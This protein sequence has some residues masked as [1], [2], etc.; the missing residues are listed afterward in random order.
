MDRDALERARRRLAEAD[1]A[2]PSAA[3]IDAVLERARAGLEGLAATAA[4]LEAAVP[5][6]LG[7]AVRASM[8]AEVLPVA[9]QIAEIRGLTGCVVGAVERVGGE[10]AAERAAR[11]EDLALLV[12][13]VA[14]GWRGVERR[15]DRMERLLDR[16]ERSLE[17]RAAAPV[18]RIEAR[19]RRTGS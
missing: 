15:L 12:D 2:G 11:V 19:E 4:E 13:L 16:V 17:D 14:S 9:R 8:E 10:I 5:E 7:A 18:Y 6:R 3:E 1:G